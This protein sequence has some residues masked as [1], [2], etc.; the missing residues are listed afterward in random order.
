[1]NRDF[2]VR[3]C[4]LYNEFH[5]I[6]SFLSFAIRL[7]KCENAISSRRMECILTQRIFHGFIVYFDERIS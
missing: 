3:Q 5:Q 2:S 4:D 1:M 7:L 6:G